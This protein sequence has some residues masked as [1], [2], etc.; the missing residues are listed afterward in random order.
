ME[1]GAKIAPASPRCHSA[2]VTL[3]RGNPRRPVEPVEFEAI[4]FLSVNRRRKLANKFTLSPSVG[5]TGRNM[6]LLRL[7]KLGKAARIMAADAGLV[8]GLDFAGREGAVE[9]E[10]LV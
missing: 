3:P 1:A 9:D 4:E 2:A 8:D 7:T 6:S 5:T 10:H